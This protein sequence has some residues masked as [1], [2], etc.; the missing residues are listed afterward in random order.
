MVGAL[1]GFQG[2]GHIKDYGEI[3]QQNGYVEQTLFMNQFVD[4]KGEIQS[5]GNQGDPLGPGSGVPESVGF[6][7]AQYGISEG[8]G[9]DCP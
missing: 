8:G 4:F 6:Y 7:E 1:A 3:N 2:V 9:G 5:A